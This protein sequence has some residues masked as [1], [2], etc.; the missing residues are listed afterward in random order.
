V[1]YINIEVEDKNTTKMLN[2]MK[3]WGKY[4][5]FVLAPAY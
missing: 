3:D 2:S 4:H 5:F 1:E